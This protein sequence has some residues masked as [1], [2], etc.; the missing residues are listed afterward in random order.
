MSSQK[1]IQS[2]ARVVRFRA[3]IV[4]TGNLKKSRIDLGKKA[5]KGKVT[6]FELDCN[7]C[8]E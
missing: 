8:R 1:D 4:K 6:A 3:C 7:I 2:F 5:Y